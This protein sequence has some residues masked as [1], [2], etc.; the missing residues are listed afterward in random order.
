[1]MLVCARPGGVLFGYAA[2]AVATRV[3]VLQFAERRQ[4]ST[5][6]YEDYDFAGNRPDRGYAGDTY[7]G[8]QPGH[9]GQGPAAKSGYDGCALLAAASPWTNEL[10]A[11]GG[12]IFK[13]PEQ[14]YRALRQR[15]FAPRTG[16]VDLDY[17]PR[18]LAK[19]VDPRLPCVKIWL[20]KTGPDPSDIKHPGVYHARVHAGELEQVLQ[21][22]LRME[23]SVLLA[24][25]LIGKQWFPL[26]STDENYRQ[27]LNHCAGLYA[28]SNLMTLCGED[29]IELQL[30]AKYLAV[31][32]RRPRLWQ[33]K[34]KSSMR[35]V[36]RKLS[37][38]RR[39]GTDV[40]II[41]SRQID[42]GTAREFCQVLPGEY[43]LI[44]LCARAQRPLDG[45]A[46]TLPEVRE[47]PDDVDNWIDWFLCRASIEQ[48]IALWDLAALRR[49]VAEGLNDNPAIMAIREACEA[50]V[51]R[52]ATIM[53]SRCRKAFISYEVLINN[54]ERAILRQALAHNE[55]NFSATARSLV[56]AESSLR[57]KLNKLGMSKAV[58]ENSQAQSQK[59]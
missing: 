43:S 6:D 3:P 31:E 49:S 32:T 9:P 40:T 39:P 37:R 55:G 42:A 15:S 5:I 33:V 11:R 35:S 27:L 2:D 14:L 4:L 44:R 7:P 50:A 17:V 20:G 8:N 18:K 51:L 19:A 23:R 29:P 41:L 54:Y 48:G 21:G 16:I 26:L 10:V 53:E 47:R 38:A 13:R 22:L 30:A 57:Y 34:S 28:R 52:H 25:G 12:R 46:L 45:P 56:L 36:L 59:N 24:T 58:S 1:M